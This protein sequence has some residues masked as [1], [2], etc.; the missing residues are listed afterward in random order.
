MEKELAGS[1]GAVRETATATEWSELGFHWERATAWGAAMSC[2]Y[3][4]AM[5]LR[6]QGDTHGAKAY[7]STAFRM[8]GAMSQ[9]AGVQSL[10]SNHIFSAR[11]PK[12]LTPCLACDALTDQ[13]A[14]E[15][16]SEA[17]L[18]ALMAGNVEYILSGRNVVLRAADLHR[19]FEQSSE[20]LY[21]GLSVVIR[22]AQ[23]LLGQDT[24]DIAYHLFENALDMVHLMRRD[25]G[26]MPDVDG[27][28]FALRNMDVCFQVFSGIFLL[29]INGQAPEVG[30]ERVR[31]MWTVVAFAAELAKSSPDF[32]AHKI[33]ALHNKVKLME[34][35][36]LQAPQLAE[37]IV[38]RTEDIHR[39]YQRDKHSQD[40]IYFYNSDRVASGTSVA[41]KVLCLQGRFAAMHKHLEY[42]HQH[43]AKIKH[44]FS[45]ASGTIGAYSIYLCYLPDVRAQ[46]IYKELQRKQQLTGNA[47]FCMAA[48][49][50]VEG[51][52]QYLRFVQ[53]RATGEDNVFDSDS[54]F[55]E[56]LL[57]SRQLVQDKQDNHHMHIARMYYTGLE[58][59]A[60]RICY[61]KALRF[62]LQYARDRSE[63]A[64]S[65]LLS[66][67]KLGL[68]HLTFTATQWA[69]NET[70]VFANLHEK[71]LRAQ[72]LLLVL[73]HSAKV[74]VKV[75]SA[76]GDGASRSVGEAQEEALRDLHYC[77]DVALRG[78]YHTVLLQVGVLMQQLASHAVATPIISDS[79]VD[80]N[81]VS[82]EGAELQSNAVRCL[83]EGNSG[84]A[85]WVGMCSAALAVSEEALL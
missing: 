41:A 50:F 84:D 11:S 58:F 82:I 76:G 6:A 78:E 51:I 28:T 68:L 14:K 61:L 16:I 15:S 85:E 71:L 45:Y 47:D 46:L 81:R 40:L 3:R 36:L 26:Q 53:Y 35:C 39:L 77:R 13:L 31:R 43:S 54:A 70:L 7:F 18:T 22:M 67:A 44:F 10:Q 69:K 56:E 74:P 21:I 19:M 2:Y 12:R 66:Y 42:A 29:H 64:L 59:V 49:L 72:L 17:D 65:L 23:A 55:V 57:Q 4:A 8:L 27:G 9:E 73:K 80:I 25:Q 30:F 37:Q 34:S 60:A 63:R 48:P 24:A 79:A 32:E 52:A 1:N 33:M 38:A 5:L 20:L 75:V 62:D 83:R